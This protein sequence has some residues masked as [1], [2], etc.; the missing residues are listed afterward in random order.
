MI[1][2]WLL[3][4]IYKFKEQ[5]TIFYSQEMVIGGKMECGKK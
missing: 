3:E 5:D 4:V 1:I 2:T